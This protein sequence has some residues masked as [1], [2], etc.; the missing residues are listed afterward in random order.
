MPLVFILLLTGGEGAF[1]L[2]LHDT[3]F[4]FSATHMAL[5]V[6]AYFGIIGAVYWVC[7]EHRLSKVL[8]WL[9]VLATSFSFIGIVVL[10]FVQALNREYFSQAFWTL[11]NIGIMLFG[12]LIFFQLVFIANLVIGL[13]RGKSVA[14]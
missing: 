5:T 7:R 12:F 2:Q 1:D 3:Y 13:L 14:H 6:S 8:S 11:N 9:H 4:V 10:T